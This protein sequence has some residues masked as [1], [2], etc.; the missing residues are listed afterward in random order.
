[1]GATVEIVMGAEQGRDDQ[2][3]GVVGPKDSLN[4]GF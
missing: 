2:A 1:M 4:D 3:A